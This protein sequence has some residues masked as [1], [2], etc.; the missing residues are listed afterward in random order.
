MCPEWNNAFI[1]PR[2]EWNVKIVGF[3]V[4]A[5]GIRGG[6]E[7]RVYASVEGKGFGFMLLASVRSV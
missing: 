5:F 3:R 7:F 1:I 2:M 4:Y 6:Q